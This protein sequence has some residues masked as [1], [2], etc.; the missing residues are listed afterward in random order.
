M[1]FNRKQDIGKYTV[2]FS[3]KEGEYAETYRVKDYNGK[4]Y[5]LKLIPLEGVWWY[6]RMEYFRGAS[7]VP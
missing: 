7:M 4:N 5:F 3:I 2:A 6:L 1:I